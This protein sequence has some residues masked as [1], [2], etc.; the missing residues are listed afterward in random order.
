M[1]AQGDM[2]TSVSEHMY[3]HMHMYMHM[4]MHTSVSELHGQTSCAGH[5]NPGVS[6][7][8]RDAARCRLAAV[9]PALA[10]PRIDELRGHRCI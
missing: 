6:K 4:H 1:H 10:P 2:H 5:P 7:I 3:K 9:S 8:S